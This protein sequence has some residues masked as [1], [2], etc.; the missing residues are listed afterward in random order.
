MKQIRISANAKLNWTLEVLGA[1]PS[2]HA[3]EG[4]TKLRSVMLLIDLADELELLID[5]GKGETTIECS[6]D[7]VPQ[8]RKG[9][10]R[11]NSCFKAI[12]EM[13]RRFSQLE[14]LDIN[15]RIHKHVPF[16][17]GLGGSSTDG[18]AVLR[19]LNEACELGLSD[20]ELADV[21]ASFGSDTPFFAT[22]FTAAL[23]EGRGEDVGGLP[24]FPKETCFVLVNPG[25]ELHVADVFS[26]L[27]KIDYSG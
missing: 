6:D 10:Q 8:K 3:N 9:N 17:G 19:A 18:S 15:V 27:R 2:G 13:R 14:N 11:E 4:Y 23:V 26:A 22:G 12:F 25:I 5:S 20:H 1:Y 24:S 7:R 21:A 16:A